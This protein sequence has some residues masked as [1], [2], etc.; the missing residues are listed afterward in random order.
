MDG[1]AKPAPRMGMLLALGAALLLPPAAWAQKQPVPA[2]PPAAAPAQPAPAQA[3]EPAP[4]PLLAGIRTLRLE[5]DLLSAPEDAPAAC[6]V[7]A[8]GLEAAVAAGLRGSGIR[9]VGR[10]PP[11][12]LSAAE[13]ADMPE[14]NT[15]IVL[16]HGRESCTFAFQLILALASEPTRLRANGAQTERGM[17]VVW[18]HNGAT[19]KAP[20]ETGTRA[21]ELLTEAV[22]D[23]AAAIARADRAA[24]AAPAAPAAVALPACPD[25]WRDLGSAAPQRLAC[26]CPAEAVARPASVWGSGTYTDDSGVCRAALHAGAVGPAG[27]RVTVVREAGRA[28][29]PGSARN[30]VT[31]SS[32]GSWGGSFRFDTNVTITTTPRSAGAIVK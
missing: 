11:A 25:R 27:G 16:L 17:V 21:R 32:Y 10:V 4:N 18:L 14:L 24:A 7:A 31:S 19:L 2:A 20:D 6:G 5:L 15:A 26:A 8:D 1:K 12:G 3:R 22:Q 29:Y 13:L 23:L 30:G 28:S 9:F